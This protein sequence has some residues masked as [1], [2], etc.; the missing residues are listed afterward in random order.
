MRSFNL[1][2]P[3][4]IA[5]LTL[6]CGGQSGH[7]GTTTTTNPPSSQQSVVVAGVVGGTSDAP[8]I[9]H[10][11]LTMTGATVVMNGLT[12]TASMV[13][14]G[15][16]ITGRGTMSGMGSMSSSG[17]TMQTIQINPSYTGSLMAMDPTSGQMTVMGQAIMTNALTMFAQENQ[18]GTYS[19]RTMADFLVGDFISVH[20][21]MQDGGTFLATRVEHRKAGMD[22]SQSGM[23]GV[24]SNLD[25][26][27]KTCSLGTL[28]VSYGSA[29]VIG[30][31]A[32]G[33]LMQVRGMVSGSQMT[34]AW[35][36]VMGSM[37]DPGSDMALRGPV[38][39][40]NTTAKTFTLMY[41][42]VNYAQ[43]TVTGTLSEGAMV[44]VQG[45]L[46]TGSTTILN[47]TK[48]EVEFMGMGGGGMGSGTANQQVMGTL[49]AIDLAGHTLTVSGT[50]F[51]MDGSTV[52]MSHD[53][54]IPASQLKVGDW[55]AVMSDTTK[56]NAAGYSYATRISEMSSGG[57]GMGSSDLMGM[58]S[59]VNASAQTLVLNGFTV[60]V[61]S[62]TAYESQGAAITATAF[63]ST[64]QAGS[65]VEA[66]GSA[67][68]VAFT[69]TRLEL[70]GMG[71]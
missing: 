33:A 58:V 30:T 26:S 48:V 13:Q 60:G 29:T 18:D 17:Y 51:W 21:A 44:E 70:R 31:P 7:P 59:T 20:G 12:A 43:A 68:G 57:S 6:A 36:N 32:N 69:A 5:G 3:I 66:K 53:A 65:R 23:M 39:N 61:T 27:A 46:A 25:S 56:K 8:Q 14:P 38:L 24:A 35:M 22:T 1:L 15:M 4:I 11:P 9:N 34:A 67:T 45:A 54:S 28:S 64:V 42:T 63:W 49:T 71:M 47:A 19:S 52:I 41:L 40:L 10:L 2:P 62:S 50:T 55:L 37:G 16:V